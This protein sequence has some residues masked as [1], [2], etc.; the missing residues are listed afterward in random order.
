MPMIAPIAAIIGTAIGVGGQIMA[1]QAQAKQ[2]RQM[3]Q[4]E[5]YNAQVSRQNAQAI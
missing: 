2:G 1:G 4:A 3:Q 5:D